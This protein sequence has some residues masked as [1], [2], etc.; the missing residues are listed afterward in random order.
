MAILPQIG[1]KQSLSNLAYEEIKE[2]IISNKFKPGEVLGEEA[3]A[4]EL[5]I[6]RTPVRSALKRLEYEQL[7]EVNPSKNMVVATVTEKDLKDVTAVRLMLE[8]L[9]ASI[10]AKL[11]TDAEIGELQKIEEKQQVSLNQRQFNE[12]IKDEY[13]FN[14]MI[15][16][17]TQNSLLYSMV[18]HIEVLIRR[19]LILSGSLSAHWKKA[20]REHDQILN[21]LILHDAQAAEKAMRRHV[22][23][24]SGRMFKYPE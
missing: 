18:D 6:S 17:F 21:A 16:R 11:I 20:M 12:F 23:N 7:I 13:L 4:A 10:S 8:P 19:A 3:L 2:A 9:A 22:E 15:A 14:T 24:A 5:V 1:K